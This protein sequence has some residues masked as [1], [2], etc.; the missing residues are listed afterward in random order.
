M[1]D[2]R[3]KGYLDFPAPTGDDLEIEPFHR[4][5]DQENIGIGVCFM[6]M[7]Q[8][9]AKPGA[10]CINVERSEQSVTQIVLQ[11]DLAFDDLV[12][13]R[14]RNAQ[15]IGE[16]GQRQTLSCGLRVDKAL[17]LLLS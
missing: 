12:Q 3:T 1:N 2:R 14:S 6:I 9:H 10:D 4:L 13:A 17:V 7:K 11:Y 15:S 8:G 5:T 16:M